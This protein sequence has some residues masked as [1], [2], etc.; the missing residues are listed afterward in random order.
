MRFKLV[1]GLGSLLLFS[2]LGQAHTLGSVTKTT[3][4]SISRFAVTC[5]DDGNGATDKDN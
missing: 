5:Y 2:S 1:I 4:A 3:E